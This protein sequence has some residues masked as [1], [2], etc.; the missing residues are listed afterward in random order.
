M[1]VGGVQGVDAGQ[2][3]DRH[4]D[5]RLAVERAD[6]S[7]VLAPSS[8]PPSVGADRP[9]HR[10]SDDV[11]SRVICP[12]V[13]GLDDD[14]AEL[15]RLGEPAQGLTVNWNACPAATGGWPSCPAATW[16]FCSGGRA[17][18]SL[19]VRLRDGQLV[20]VEPDAHAVV[21]LAETGHVADARRAGP[22]RP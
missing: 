10:R 5:R 2:L 4:A 9:R 18:T 17:T 19:A 13:A 15:L 6:V 7:S 16:T 12:S 3:E 20:R 11:R 21:L 14:V 1:R 8:M 22:A